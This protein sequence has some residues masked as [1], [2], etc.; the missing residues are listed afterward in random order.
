MTR[1]SKP[2]AEQFADLGLTNPKHWTP[3]MELAVKQKWS[4][5]PIGDKV[6]DLRAAIADVVTDVTPSPE[7]LQA[8]G[9]SKDVDACRVEAARLKRNATVNAWRKRN[10]LQ[11]ALD[12]REM[13]YAAMR[14]AR[15][16]KADGNNNPGL[17]EAAS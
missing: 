7:M 3:A 1:N 8:T 17:V 4:N 9:F 12:A 10:Q 5:L 2:A 13:R 11:A 16:H 15:T 14:A 6:D